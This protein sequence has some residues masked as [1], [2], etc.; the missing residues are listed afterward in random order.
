MEDKLTRALVEQRIASLNEQREELWAQLNQVMG[1][2]QILETLLPL[3]PQDADQQD[4]KPT[5]PEEENDK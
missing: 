3:L 1:A 2:M 5:P 4:G